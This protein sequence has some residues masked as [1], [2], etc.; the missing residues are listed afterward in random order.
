MKRPASA[1]D[2]VLKR[3][4]LAKKDIEAERLKMAIRDNIVTPEVKADG[5]GG[6]DAARYARAV[7]EELADAIAA[8]LY[9]PSDDAQPLLVGAPRKVTS[10]A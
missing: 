1:V 9:G 8:V 3:N 6:I 4:D 5:Y 2:S 10:A 7:Y